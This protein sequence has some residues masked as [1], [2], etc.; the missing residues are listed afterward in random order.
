MS[1]THET[2]LQLDKPEARLADKLVFREDARFE[3]AREAWNLAVDQQP[4]AVGLPESVEDVIAMT[5]FATERGLRVAPQ[6]TGHAA[7]ALDDLAGTLLL[8]TSSIRGVRI[9]PDARTARAQ[10]GTVWADVT[11]AAAPHGL[12]ALAGSAADVGVVGY[13]L[14]G[15]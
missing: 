4:A 15:G 5:A 7:E 12:A 2:S 9:D 13:T 8:K 6:S 10:A 11:A 3:Q 14:G 1:A